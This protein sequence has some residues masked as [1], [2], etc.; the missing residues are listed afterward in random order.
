MERIRQELARWTE[1]PPALL[2]FRAAGALV[3]AIVPGAFT[4]WLAY[5]II[6]A[7]AA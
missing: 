3:I 5:R 6:R 7:R 1:G 4:V 2:A